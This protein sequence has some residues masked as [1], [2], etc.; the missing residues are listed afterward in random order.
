MALNE[1]FQGWN[2]VASASNTSGWHLGRFC[3]ARVATI[4]WFVCVIPSIHLVTATS[5][6]RLVPCEALWG[7][8]LGFTS[9]VIGYLP[10]VR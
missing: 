3:L 6:D 9:H 8:C 7:E 5:E 2:N 10:S 4:C 1:F